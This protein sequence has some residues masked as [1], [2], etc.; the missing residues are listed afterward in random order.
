MPVGRSSPPS[1]EPLSVVA[2]GQAGRPPPYD[3]LCPFRRMARM[4][5]G[6]TVLADA[7]RQGTFDASTL[8]SESLGRRPF[9]VNVLPQALHRKRRVPERFGRYGTNGSASWPAGHARAT[10][11]GYYSTQ[12]AV[13]FMPSPGS[14][15]R[16]SDSPFRHP[17]ASHRYSSNLLEGLFFRRGATNISFRRD[18]FSGEST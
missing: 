16:S 15:T 5:T 9:G 1:F 6:V 8:P 14:N 17:F 13:Q 12:N 10:M 4:R 18:T 3:S 7:L 11:T 2:L